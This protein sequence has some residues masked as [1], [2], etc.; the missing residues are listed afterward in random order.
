MVSRYYDLKDENHLP[1]ARF[2]DP[3]NNQIYLTTAGESLTSFIDR[4]EKSRADKNLPE[5]GRESLRL[6]IITTFVEN[7][8]PADL[9]KYFV[10]K[11]VP[12]SMEQML[13]LAR[14]LAVSHSKQNVTS[15]VDR[16]NRAAK[17]RTCKFHQK[18]GVMSGLAVK[19]LNAMSGL[20]SIK[21]SDAERALGTCGMCGCA[22]QAKIRYPVKGVLAGTTP[23]NIA[24]LTS[25]YGPRAFDVCWILSESLADTDTRALL[26]AKL[27]HGLG[28]QFLTAY[29]EEKAQTARSGSGK[30]NT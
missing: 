10:L 15:F 6:L 11:P 9:Q 19:M 4:I 30:D 27:R 22:L 26:E 14:T 24:K 5:I 13:A 12:V 2:V 17:C 28:L 8:S 25:A 3:V 23:D 7:S 21:Q 29:D 18:S 16:Q 1:Q 20:E